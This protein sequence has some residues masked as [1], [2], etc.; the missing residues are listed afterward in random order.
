MI[1]VHT[2]RVGTRAE[3]RHKARPALLLVAGLSLLTAAGTGCAN[4]R[5][6]DKSLAEAYVKAL[7]HEVWDD[8]A[9]IY[10]A[11]CADVYDKG[12]WVDRTRIEFAR[13]IRQSRYG[14]FGPTHPG[15]HVSS[16]LR[17]EVQ[18]DGST[19]SIPDQKTRTARGPVVMVYCLGDDV[20]D[21]VWQNL[22]RPWRD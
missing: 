22:E 15:R 2:P 18:E 12:T 17:P 20:P 11:Y 14:E 19:D 7:E 21:E 6:S 13:E 16:I 5:N 9:Q 8:L 1:G 3:T 4:A 10:S